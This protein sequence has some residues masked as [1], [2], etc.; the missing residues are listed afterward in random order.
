[1]SQQL[2]GKTALV[3]VSAGGIGLAI[4]F[5]LVAEGAFVIVIKH[6]STAR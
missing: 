1:M 5:A 2:N 4:A 6:A 3:T